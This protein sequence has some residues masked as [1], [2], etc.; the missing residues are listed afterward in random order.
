MEEVFGAIPVLY[1]NA[2]RKQT[3]ETTDITIQEYQEMKN[4]EIEVLKDYI[5]EIC[6]I[7]YMQCPLEQQDAWLKAMMDRRLYKSELD[8]GSE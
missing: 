7:I 4:K 3:M 5:W 1:A 2:L 8:N 6:D